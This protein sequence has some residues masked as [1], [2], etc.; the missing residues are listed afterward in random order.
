MLVAI[1]KKTRGRLSTYSLGLSVRMRERFGEKVGDKARMEEE[2]KERKAGPKLPNDYLIHV[3][4]WLG[5][6]KKY[7]LLFKASSDGHSAAAFHAKCDNK[8]PTVTLITCTEGYVFG[9]YAAVSWSYA[10][11]DAYIPDNSGQS[12]LFSL[13]SPRGEQPA[14][15]NLKL[16]EYA[17]RCH[18]SYSV[19][20]GSGGDIYCHSNKVSSFSS[21]GDAYDNPTGLVGN[22]VFTGKQDFTAQEV[23]VYQVL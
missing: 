5:G 19:M 14:R 13:K 17:L 20:F 12:F 7:A 9:G 1:A 4:K 10:G 3:D 11:N 18:P 16:N 6:S 15:F 8:G 2:E 21:L 22:T 23:E